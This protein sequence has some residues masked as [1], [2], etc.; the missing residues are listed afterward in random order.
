MTVIPPY[1]ASGGPAKARQLAVARERYRKV[2]AA[3]D[4]ELD[5]AEAAFLAGFE[6]ADE[7]KTAQDRIA[8]LAHKTR[9]I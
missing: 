7:K 5:K 4:A 3:L 6:R 9:R 2:V 8:A 1:P